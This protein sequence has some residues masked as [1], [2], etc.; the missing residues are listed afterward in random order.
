VLER[1]RILAA[2]V[3][4]FGHPVARHLKKLFLKLVI[5][6]KSGKPHALAGV[7]HA[8]LIRGVP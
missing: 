4:G 8:F 1:N 3:H 7:F 6:R 2:L 5:S